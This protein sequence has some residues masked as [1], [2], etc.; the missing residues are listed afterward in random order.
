[1]NSTSSR[2]E[3]NANPHELSKF[4][5]IQLIFFEKTGARRSFKHH[6]Q[7]QKHLNSF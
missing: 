6:G 2:K 5:S 3:T 7:N 1:M 4:V